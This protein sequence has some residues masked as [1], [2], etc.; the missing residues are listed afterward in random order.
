MSIRQTVA[1]A[2]PLSVIAVLYGVE[3][4]DELI[5][6]LQSAV[7]PQLKIDL[8][9][10]YTQVG[11]LFTV[12]GLIGI[13]GAPL[14]GLLGDT[15]HR[16]VLVIGGIVATAMGLLFVAIGQTFF[17][18]L[19]AFC[20]L[21]VSSDAYVNLP[22]AT[23]IDRDPSRAEQTMARWTLLG[24]I[25]VTVA[26]LVVTALFYLGYG[27]RGLY[28]SLAGV[29]GVYTA[30]L[31]RQRFD[32]HAGAEKRASP[33]EMWETLVR[34]LKT[35]E[36]LRWVI[37][38]EL[39]DLMMDK[40]LEVTGLYFHDVVGVSAAAAS[41]AVAVFTLAGLVGNML[42]V[43]ALEKV[44]GLS[45]LRVSSAL[46]L[47]AYVAFLLAPITWLKFVLIGVI[48]FSTTGW[49]AILRGRTYAVLP[50]QSGLVVAVTSLANVSS[51]FVP[52]IVGRIADAFGLSWAMWL[53]A[54]G[55]L[56]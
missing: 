34:A 10:T 11:L 19:F 27:W 25:G 22:Q 30:L 37:V 33:R 42:L 23:L 8:A 15:R 5:Y 55:P 7:L 1:N 49:F 36:L 52:L 41:G 56:A 13:V 54:L 39:A 2:S 45:V 31:L 20:I 51:V 48:S 43:P 26:P 44:S 14:I 4:L 6:G 9:L 3:L 18:I 50:G 21:Y 17:I 40:L 47:A 32:A 24:A 38:T 12:P 28:L 16:R 53:L 35:R 46:V 29:A